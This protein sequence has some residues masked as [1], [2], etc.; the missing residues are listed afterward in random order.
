[1]SIEHD[2]LKELFVGITDTEV[3]TEPQKELRSHDPHAVAEAELDR[4]V[5]DVA[6]HKELKDAIGSPDKK[7]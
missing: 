4:A 7:R 2:A 1:M 3:L 5:S 6:Q